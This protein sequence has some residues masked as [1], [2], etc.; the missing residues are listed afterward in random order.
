MFGFKHT[1]NNFN[2]NEIAGVK[3]RLLGRLIQVQGVNNLPKIF[4]YL[5]KR[6]QQS[7]DEQV[8][9]DKRLKDG[10]SLSVA[11]TIRTVT[12]RVMAV[13]FF[14]EQTSRDP[15]FADALIRHPQEM[16]KC[17]AAFQIVPGF[18]SS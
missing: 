10:V 8:A 16:V 14:G 13:L 6:V 15:V 18:L 2:H 11:S 3:S 7:L 1:L 9:L 17:M 4:P 12:S 5:N